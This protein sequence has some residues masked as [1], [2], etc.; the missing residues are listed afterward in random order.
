MMLAIKILT[1]M[2]V[3]KW[4]ML[5]VIHF[6]NDGDNADKNV[7]NYYGDVATVIYY[8]CSSN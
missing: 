3:T 8:C 1:S 6:D 7:D 5:I 2:L 4:M